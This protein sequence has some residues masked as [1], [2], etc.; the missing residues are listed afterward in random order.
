MACKW[1]LLEDLLEGSEAMRDRRTRWLPKHEKE[2]KRSYDARLRRSF[3]FGAFKEV[4]FALSAKPFAEPV[5]LKEAERLPER[6]AGIEENADRTGRNLTDWGREVFRTALTY[7]LTHV[8][9]DFPRNPATIDGREVS[10]R[11]EDEFGLRAR[12]LHVHPRNL[13]GWDTVTDPRTGAEILTR[14]RIHEERIEPH[15][16]FGDQI[17]EWVTIYT[18]STVHR[19]RKANGDEDFSPTTPEPVPHTFGG[20]PLVTFYTNRFGIL[21]ADPPF[22]DLADL[23]LQHWQVA[24]DFSN[25][26]H[27]S[28]FAIL[29]AKG[30]PKEEWAT[31]TVG[32]TSF[33]KTESTEAELSYVEHA[34]RA[35]GSAMEDIEK[36]EERME[37][38]GL[39]PLM[40]RQGNMT[41]TSAGI[42]H[43]RSATQM[44]A[45]AEGFERFITLCYEAAARWTRDSLPEGFAAELHKDFD[46]IL[47]GGEDVREL[48]E[49]RKA[50]FLTLRTYLQEIQ[51]RGLISESIDIDEE[52]EAVREESETE[53]AA[54]EPGPG[55]VDD[56][57][58]E[59][60][61]FAADPEGD[62]EQAEA[63]SGFAF[64]G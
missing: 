43:G 48:R 35:T 10:L 55:E 56:S 51:K 28:R 59:G 4:I 31:M 45:W 30:I 64:R 8:L 60:E 26:M 40:R 13:I 62:P 22:Q 15:G 11:D 17:V 34:A 2:S 12:L 6:L 18:R 38:M 33:F 49:A 52:V 27:F 41:A 47:R 3:L 14:I 39:N 19:F 50:R 9:V 61:G 42:N 5:T 23:N 36:I 54:L 29:F 58:P 25:I 63:G 7:G 20:I 1:D 24:S 21:Q 44:S 57:G 16:E 46:I 37:R 32:P 53:L